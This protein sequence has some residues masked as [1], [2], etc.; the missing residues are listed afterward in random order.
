VTGQVLVGWCDPGQVRGEFTVSLMAMSHHSRPRIAGFT[1]KEGG[2]YIHRHR[3]QMVRE[4]LERGD[5]EWLLQ[6]DSDMTFRHDLLER[7]LE[8]ADPDTVPVLSAL[9]FG[10]KADKGVH[11]IM[12]RK[13]TSY[14]RD[15]KLVG[16]GFQAIRDY[17]EDELIEVGAVGTG[18]LLTHISVFEKTR[19]DEPSPWFHQSTVPFLEGGLTEI[20]E[21]LTFCLRCATYDIPIHVH[22]G[23][24]TGHIKNI[25]WNE[26]GYRNEKA[27]A[28]SRRV[29]EPEAVGI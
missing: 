6:V 26:A 24:A 1:R 19:G 11:P 2:A 25:E 16:Y 22:T 9:N 27:A 7:M 28:A 21:D 20:G 15:D 23:I 17:P 14:T 3:N 10:W 12:Y 4:L 13:A 18:C 29:P 5:S 8:V